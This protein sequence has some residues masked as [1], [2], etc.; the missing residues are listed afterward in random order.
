MTILTK[1][2]LAMVQFETTTGKKPSLVYL[3]KSELGSLTELCR[4]IEADFFGGRG[5]V[6]G[7]QIVEV[8][9]ESF[10]SVG[11]DL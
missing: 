1:I 3:G 5:R 6:A 8:N 2:T 7:L 9:E 11:L 4:E 10:V